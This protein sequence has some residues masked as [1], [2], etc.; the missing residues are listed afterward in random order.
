[1]FI[2]MVRL[3]GLAAAIYYQRIAGLQEHTLRLGDVFKLPAMHRFVGGD[4]G[5]TTE[6]RDIEQHTTRYD[7]STPV[8][9]TPKGGPLNGNFLA[10]TGAIPHALAVQGMKRRTGIG[11]RIPM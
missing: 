7:P 3:Q 1:V 4:I 9:D 11:R 2:R 8:V 5:L 6:L 10:W